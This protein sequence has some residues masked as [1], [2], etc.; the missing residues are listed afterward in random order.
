M[1][2]P[3]APLT[4]ARLGRGLGQRHRVLLLASVR[5][6]GALS[7][8]LSVAAPRRRLPPPPPRHLTRSLAAATDVSEPQ[9]E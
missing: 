8:P 6:Y 5:H 9:A 3:L 1:A 4:A 7:A 2:A